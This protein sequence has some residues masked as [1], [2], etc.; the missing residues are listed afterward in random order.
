MQEGPDGPMMGM[1]GNGYG[2]CGNC[3]HCGNCGGGGTGGDDMDFEQGMCG[4]MGPWVRNLSVFAGVQGFK[5]AMD[6]GNNG[7]F[8]VHEGINFGAPLGDPWGIGYQLGFQAVQSDLQGFYSR[9]DDGRTEFQDNCRGQIFI[10]AGLFLRQPDHGFQGG[11][12]FDY[13][14]DNYYDNSN[15]KQVRSETSYLFNHGVQEVGYWGAYRLS[16]DRFST[17]G[18][19]WLESTDIF[20]IFYRHHF[21]GGGQGRIWIGGTGMGDGVIGGE[22]TIPLGTSWALENSFTYMVPKHGNET[23]VQEETWAVAMSLVWYPGR[24]ARCVFKNPFTPILPVADNGTF[25]TRRT[26]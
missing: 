17:N 18:Y 10:T 11:V 26:D 12:T 20:A 2:G 3:G 9:N 8:G 19:V 13:M 14:R 16:S 6:R 15:L 7:N 24:S 1:P 23:G 5:G 22:A 21:S 4:C 25:L